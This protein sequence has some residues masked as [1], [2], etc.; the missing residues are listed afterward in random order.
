VRQASR[1]LTAL[2]TAA[3]VGCGGSTL[4]SYGAPQ[5][6]VLREEEFQGGDLIRYRALTRD[7]FRGS[8][9]QGPA[10][11][12][13]DK[14][15]AQTF[16][17]VRHDPGVQFEGKE[18]TQPNGKRRTVG[19]IRNLVFRAWMDRSR[20]WWNPKKGQT[21][22]D[23]V[24]EHEQIHFALVE[25]ESAVMNR[26]GAALMQRTFEGT[27]REDLQQQI[28]SAINEI[29]KDGMERLL[30][31]NR[32]FDEATSGRYDPKAQNEWWQRVQRG[33][34][35]NERR[36]LRANERREVATGE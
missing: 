16:A 15:G 18:A 19:K 27:E 21:P 8:A 12:H 6:S 10:A 9:P 26:E 33:L 7:D 17:L 3:L 31:A 13:V 2:G 14:V 24:L 1:W 30:E 25:L 28:E 4:P 22:E 5:G 23:Y 34:A 32:D 20:S 29:V 36:A 35:E 11:E